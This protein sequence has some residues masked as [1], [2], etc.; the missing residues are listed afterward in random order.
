[1]G[2]KAM[3]PIVGIGVALTAFLG[4]NFIHIPQQR[5]VSEIEANIAEVRALQQLQ[6]EVMTLLGQ[7]ERYRRQLPPAAD[8][9]WLV[10]QVVALGQRDGIELDTISQQGPQPLRQFT[11]LAVDLQFTATY[12]QLG[13]FLDDIERSAYFLQ[14]EEI[15]V[16]RRPSDESRVDV[17]LRV[18]TFFVP[19]TLNGGGSPL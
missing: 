3:L 2:L 10:N 12:H 19:P 7:V 15:T 9:S 16:N 6:T 4:Y 14:A 8:P 13:R 17:R 11:R 1:M 5:K 18:A